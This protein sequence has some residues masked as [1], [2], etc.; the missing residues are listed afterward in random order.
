MSNFCPGP[1]SRRSFLQYGGLTMLGMNL[2]DMFKFKAQANSIITTDTNV[3]FIWLPGGPPHMEM[4]DLKPEAPM[5]YRGLFR[6]IKTNVSGMDISELFPLQAKIADKFNIIRSV[7]HDFAD[8]GGG[9]K[10]FMT[11]RIP[12][13]PT[14]TV[15]DAPAVTSIVQKC[16]T[17][18]YGFKEGMPP[19]VLGGTRGG[20]D[21]FA[22]GPA[23]LGSANTPFLVPGD[24]SDRNFKV[25]NLGISKEFQT[26]LEDRMLLRKELDNFKRDADSSGVIKAMDTFSQSAFEMLT[27]SK[28][29]DAFDISQENTRT[30]DQYGMTA[31]G[32]SALLA[33]RLVESGCRF[34]EMVWENPYP[35]RQVPADCSYNWDSHAV[36]CNL[37]NDARWRFPVYDQAVSALIEDLYQRGLDKKTMLIVTG[38]FGRTPKVSTAVGTQSKVTQPGRDHWPKSMSMIMSG[39][40]M[41]TGQVIGATNSRG[42]YPVERPLTPN[43]VWATVYQHLGIDYTDSFLDHSGRPMPILPF[44]EAIEELLYKA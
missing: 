4:Y 40:G 13:T 34:V 27:N 8:H 21:A 2:L 30:R 37:Y 26:R 15:N 19:V 31:Y 10:R 41:R 43:D 36:N 1:F 29:S 18:K 35:S 22:N 39:G 33:R 28:V 38:E 12:A 9:H 5:E 14:G 3:I 32:Q 24:P 23:Y 42:E 25:Q 11:G 17:E 44:G 7:S 6:P 20:I 16:I